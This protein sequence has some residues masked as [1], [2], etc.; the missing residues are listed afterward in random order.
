MA[1]A[2]HPTALGALACVLLAILAPGP[3]VAGIGG[4]RFVFAPGADGHASCW[5]PSTAQVVCFRGDARTNDGEDVDGAI[6]EFPEDW[7]VSGLSYVGGSGV[8]DG[9]G[10]FGTFSSSANA[11]APRGWLVSH[12]L[13]MGSEQAPVDHCTSLY[14]ADVVTGAGDGLPATIPWY[15]QGSGA[16]GLPHTTSS[17]GFV[18]YEGTGADEQIH[19][20]IAI[21][22]CSDCDTTE[23]DCADGWDDDCDGLV[24][25]ADGDCATDVVCLPRLETEPND[26]PDTEA[27]D[28]GALPI[29]GQ[30]VFCGTIDPP[31]DVDQV[32]FQSS[33]P[34]Q[35]LQ[36]QVDA[37]RRGSPLDPVVAIWTE[38]SGDLEV[39][40]QNDDAACDPIYGHPASTCARDAQLRTTLP[41]SGTSWVV[42]VED[43]YGNGGSDHHYCLILRDDRAPVHHGNTY[44]M[45]DPYWW[46]DP[47]V[48][49]NGDQPLPGDRI[50]VVNDDFMLTFT[51][52]AYGA[53]YRYRLTTPCTLVH[54]TDSF[55]GSGWRD[56]DYYTW[57]LQDDDPAC[58]HWAIGN[59]EDN[60]AYETTD[61]RFVTHAIPVDPD[62]CGA[63]PTSLW[64]DQW[65]YLYV[66]T[67]SPLSIDA[68]TDIWCR[69]EVEPNGIAAPWSADGTDPDV[70]GLPTWIVPL[71]TV[72]GVIDVSAPFREGPGDVDQDLFAFAGEAGAPV[73][74]DVWAAAAGSGA[75]PLTLTLFDPEG[76]EVASVDSQDDPYL[77]VEALPV[78]GTYTLLLEEEVLEAGGPD[79]F[80][81][82]SL[83]TPQCR[84]GD[85]DGYGAPAHPHCAEAEED[86]DDTDPNINPAQTADPIDLEDNDCD[87]QVDEDALVFGDLVIN[88]LSMS[89]FPPYEGVAFIEVANNTAYS[90]GGAGARTLD[91]IG[92]YGEQSEGK[93]FTIDEHLLVAPGELVV[94][95]STD[96]PDFIDA[97]FAFDY[98]WE[99]ILF[100]VF[101]DDESPG[102]V[103]VSNAGSMTNH[104]GGGDAVVCQIS[105]WHF[106]WPEGCGYRGS[107]ALGGEYLGPGAESNNDLAAY[108][109]TDHADIL[110]GGY[111]ASPGSLNAQCCWDDDDHDGGYSAECG[112]PDCDDWDFTINGDDLDGD[113]SGS[114]EDCDDDDPTLEWDDLDGDGFA[115]CE[116]DCA[117]EDPVVSPG[118][119]EDP[120][121]LADDDCDGLIDECAYEETVSSGSINVSIPDGGYPASMA[122]VDLV[123]ADHGDAHDLVEQVSL[124]V[125]LTHTWVGDLVITLASPV[126][127]PVTVLERPGF[128]EFSYGYPSNAT[129]TAPVAFADHHPRDAG[130]YGSRLLGTQRVCAD[131]GAC[132]FRPEEPFAGVVGEAAPG[133]WQVCVGDAAGSDTGTLRGADLTLRRG[134][135]MPSST[136]Y[137]DGDEDGFGDPDSAVVTCFPAADALF[138]GGD[139]D[140]EEVAI[141]PG[142][143]EVCDGID[144]DCDGGIDDLDPQGAADASVW[145]V[146]GDGDAY[147]YAGGIREACVEPEGYVADATDC[148]DEAA[149]VNPAATEV[150][151]GVD[152]DC[153]GGSDDADPEGPADPSTWYADADGD[154]YGDPAASLSACA[155]PGHVAGA[156]D[157]DDTRATVHPGAVEVCNALDDD[158]DATTDEHG[159]ADGDGF[160]LCDGDCDDTRDDVN[161]GA[162][163]VCGDALDADCDGNA[164]VDD[165]DCEEPEPEEEGCGCAHG[166]G[167][168]GVLVGFAV[169]GVA[170]RRR[171]G[172]LAVVLACGLPLAGARATPVSESEPN[173]T[174]DDADTLEDLAP[175]T[176]RIHC[177]TIDPA[178]D[179]DWFAFRT[180]RE[181]QTVS[182][183]VDAQR[184]ASPMDP[185]VALWLQD[186][187][188]LVLYDQNDDAA[189]DPFYGPEG[190]TC[191]RDSHLRATLPTVDQWAFV[192][193]EDRDAFG[194]T[195]FRYC[196]RVR[197]DE[198]LVHLDDEEVTPDVYTEGRLVTVGGDLPLPEDRA[199][200]V[201]D[202]WGS[203]Y[204]PA[205]EAHTLRYHLGTPCT[206]VHDTD[207]LSG[208]DLEYGYW[209]FVRPGDCSRYEAASDVFN[210]AYA[211]ADP[212]FV[213][214]AAAVDPAGCD[215]VPK[216]V[217][218]D[219][220]YYLPVYSPSPAETTAYTD[221]SCRTEVEPNG[222][223]GAPWSQ[224]L[225]ST[226]VQNPPTAIIPLETVRGVIDAADPFHDDPGAADVD[227]FAFEA[228]E[229]DPVI[230]DVWAAEAG[231]GAGPLTVTLYDPT[232]SMVEGVS[233]DDPHL[234]VGPLPVGGT[235]Y[236]AVEETGDPAGGA[237]HVYALSVWKPM[238]PDED[239]DGYGSPIHPHC[240]TSK[241]DC[242]DA[243]PNVNPAVEADLYDLVD[244]DCD[245]W[246]DED[247]LTFGDVV[248]TEAFVAGSP[249]WGTLSWFEV[250]NNTADNPGGQGART[251]DL[252][253][254]QAWDES[255]W[256]FSIKDHLLFDP[257]E[258]LVFGPTHDPAEN[259]GI[260]FDYLWGDAEVDLSPAAYGFL[261]FSDRRGPTGGDGGGGDR[262]TYDV[263]AF[264]WPTGVGASMEFGGEYLGPEAGTLNDWPVYWCDGAQALPGGL[265]GSPGE[266]NGQCCWDDVDG[267]GAYSAACGG[268]DCDDTDPDLH[269]G[270][271]DLDGSDACDDCDD[272]DPAL[273]AL[274]ADEDGF[275]T[276]E[277][278]CDDADPLVN[279]GVVEDTSNGADDD[280]D[281]IVDECAYE[282]IVVEGLG[283]DLSVPDGAY[284]GTAASMACVDLVVEDRDDGHDLV[285]HVTLTLGMTHPR[286][287]DLVV[288]LTSPTGTVVT[289]LAQPG[290]DEWEYGY[291][292]FLSRFH[293]LEFADHHPVD[294]DELGRGLEFKVDCDPCLFHPS[295]AGGGLFADFVGEEA[296]GTWSLCVGDARTQQTGEIDYVA[297]A[298]RRGTG[299][300]IPTVY[301]DADADTYGD[302]GTALATCFPPDDLIAVG[303]DCDD[304]DPEVHP[305]AT[306]VCDRIDNDC[307]G[308]IDAGATDALTWYADADGDA[309]GDPAATVDACEQPDGHVADATDC[310]DTDHTVHP[311]AVE[312]CDTIDN[313]CDGGTD[314]L[315]PEGP[316]D[317]ATWH[318]DADG[319]GFGDPAVSFVA[320]EPEG[321]VADATDCDD[322]S[323]AVHPGAPEV[324]NAGVDDD[325]NPATDEEGDWDRDGASICDG[326]CDDFLGSVHPDAVEVCDNHLDDDCDGDVDADDPDC[327][328]P[329]P[330]ASCSCAHGAHPWGWLPLAGLLCVALRRRH[331]VEPRV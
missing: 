53:I 82:L 72:R 275:S 19:G 257:G 174:S 179:V 189:C 55:A 288:D 270:D 58:I 291:R 153:D 156:T 306:E 122:C 240:E 135:G 255:G 84:D 87:G 54:D 63:T 91:L 68:Y 191:V 190:S 21:R 35:T 269:D 289:L 225:T 283:L 142:A 44:D 228:E 182:V 43:R 8:C 247:A 205:T 41:V 180:T 113:G 13:T 304:A 323:T 157:C 50:H 222:A 40:D 62:G 69:S 171:R 77:E 95:G 237:D 277:G 6:V 121:N 25:C 128:H 201:A 23:G 207:T 290:L 181:L 281:G 187:E 203:S 236:I 210:G 326:D 32:L 274:D 114:C 106:G 267:D 241:E 165:P 138:R 221:I 108:W 249:P 30:R 64:N 202:E 46:G 254:W 80:Y 52:W 11:D 101:E 184:R 186:G 219:G 57:G 177:G 70:Q 47:V 266:V 39:Y 93:R 15:W 242:D 170:L 66:T 3:A 276:C 300:P 33:R 271:D 24:D 250:T 96:D 278:D 224:D 319:D 28:L 311:G 279:P 229:D 37:Q 59:H 298:V 7:T 215:T 161:P 123:F 231:S 226:L 303:G 178:G 235:Y 280:C 285:E 206:V 176:E 61:P 259:P 5:A 71:E 314:D 151:N 104:A 268:P 168:P 172:V 292:S 183:R 316:V 251:I 301:V 117:D 262:V 45:H 10:G 1:R 110:P 34:L 192:S 115:T 227:F 198:A 320:C 127:P 48:P 284:D 124:S 20:E 287:G 107:M 129:Y 31:G 65:F 133:T 244:N 85:G 272:A 94:L 160:S 36:V 328:E 295:A 75:G 196:L 49:L 327:D 208:Q 317:P 232:G 90:D 74:V 188:D 118:V 17:P 144:N 325:C 60:G 252:I 89:G 273:E 175:S 264:G 163:E 126:G 211:S 234:E 305:D 218:N 38:Q 150:C 99:A 2:I 27:E 105:Q 200:V 321:R 81:A 26:D 173:D 197:D 120:T 293:W 331:G 109:C 98:A 282:D 286:V 220:V 330:E 76:T 329:V 313:D 310:D 14:C 78:D 169:L 162:V 261:Y 230:V 102:G 16:G 141:H 116:G 154:G 223:G 164:D 149:A 246:V 209:F 119:I 18:P 256:L 4:S 213:S 233:G 312:V 73:M 51:A 166:A 22:P 103:Y 137:T 193:V 158:C 147:G 318:P 324:C 322:G 12:E 111:Y 253:G 9:D 92:W 132:T 131:D 308:A 67:P 195:D 143:V 315:D 100:F 309:F 238:C 216:A 194:G 258:V 217:W 263:E 56:Y 42:S 302:P 29:G 294:A 97:G 152:D 297:L 159:D 296:A 299:T 204:Y 243:D 134:T 139:C 265:Y 88:E 248:I 125:A 212:R 83:W 86:C 155:P 112:G 136:V 148:D 145:Y 167:A 260:V 185:V 140:D 146:D 245:K 199:H 79:H 307:D 239:G 214:H 130:E